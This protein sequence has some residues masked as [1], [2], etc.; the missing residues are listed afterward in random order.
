MRTYWVMDRHGTD[1]PTALVEVDGRMK[2][3]NITKFG[4]DLTELDAQQKVWD[5][6]IGQVGPTLR[7]FVKA[8]T[9]SEPG[10]D[11]HAD[12]ERTSARNSGSQKRGVRDDGAGGGSSDIHAGGGTF[13]RS[14]GDR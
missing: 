8:S 5:D 7:P 11:P 9:V 6:V 1:G 12:L 13:R 14:A 10:I 3:V 2:I 4:P